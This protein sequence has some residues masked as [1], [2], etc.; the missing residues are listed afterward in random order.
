MIVPNGGSLGTL[1][2]YHNPIGD[3]TRTNPRECRLAEIHRDHRPSGDFGV[4]ARNLQQEWTIEPD[5]A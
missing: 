1:K 3:R 5:N 2:T 4:S